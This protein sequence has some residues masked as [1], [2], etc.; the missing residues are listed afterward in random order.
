ALMDFIAAI[1]RFQVT[2]DLLNE[3]RRERIGIF[4]QVQLNRLA[5]QQRGLLSRNLSVFHHRVDHQIAASQRPIGMINGRVV[6]G[7]LRQPCQ[8]RRF[9]QI[10]LLRRFAEVV[11][12][13]CL[14][15]ISAMTEKNLVGV[16]REDLRLG[17]ASLD[18]DRQHDFLDLAVKGAIRS[19]KQIARKLH[20]ERGGALQLAA[21]DEI[22]IGG[23]D[24]APVVD[25]SMALKILVFHGSQGIAQNLWIVFVGRYHSTLQGKG[26]NDPAM[27]VIDIGHRTGPIVFKLLYLRKVIRIDQQQ[28]GGS[29]DQGRHQDEQSK[30]NSPDEPP[31]AD[32]YPRRLYIGQMHGDASRIARL[33]T[34]G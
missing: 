13:S 12:G 5:F 23:A 27:I 3:I 24:H 16:K 9:L 20:G 8:Q 11:A 30:H 6:S 22:T 21:R 4:L 18:L 10:Q 26:P 29:A 2:S 32:L 1:F 25:S 33:G 17:K 19:Q 31:A 7:R 14:K 34:R 28:S 15:T